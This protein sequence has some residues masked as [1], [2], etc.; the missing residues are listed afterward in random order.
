M[1][2]APT[3]N[4]H[5]PKDFKVTVHAKKCPA[6]HT[7]R[8]ID[9]RGLMGVLCFSSLALNQMIFSLLELQLLHI[10]FDQSIHLLSCTIGTT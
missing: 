5:F 8:V 2:K 3:E 1:Q 7:S 10:K 4:L 9:Q 6:G